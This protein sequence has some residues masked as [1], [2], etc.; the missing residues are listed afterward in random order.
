MEMPDALLCRGLGNG[1]DD[2]NH[3]PGTG[4]TSNDGVVPHQAAG[5]T[6]GFHDG[7]LRGKPGRERLNRHVALV[8]VEELL[9]EA[10]GALDR[11]AKALK[12][13]NVDSHTDDHDFPLVWW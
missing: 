4:H 10:R 6:E 3:G 9:N 13:D 7:L 8:R 11:G 12:V 5:R 1:P 2:L